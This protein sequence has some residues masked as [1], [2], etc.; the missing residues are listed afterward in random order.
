MQE[1]EEAVANATVADAFESRGKSRQSLYTKRL[2]AL[3][4]HN[5]LRKKPTLAD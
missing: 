5:N 2:S 3:D 4:S 1:R